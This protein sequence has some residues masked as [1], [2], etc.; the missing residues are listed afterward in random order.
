[1]IIRSLRNI[2]KGYN[3]RGGVLIDT[4]DEPPPHIT[5]ET[6]GHGKVS[7]S[8]DFPKEIMLNVSMHSSKI[9]SNVTFSRK[10]GDEQVKTISLYD[11]QKMDLGSAIQN[12]FSC[13]A[14]VKIS[15]ENG[16]YVLNNDDVHKYFVGKTFDGYQIVTESDF[17]YTKE[18]LTIQYPIYEYVDSDGIVLQNGCVA[19]RIIYPYGGF[20]EYGVH[21]KR[22]EP[23]VFFI[24]RNF[25]M[26]I[27]PLSSIRDL[28]P[29]TDTLLKSNKYFVGV[30]NFSRTQKQSLYDD[31]LKGECKFNLKYKNQTQQFISNALIWHEKTN[32]MQIHFIQK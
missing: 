16:G 14:E 10:I 1:M 24:N 2:S 31:I 5:F 6:S 19:S 4:S 3:H 11:S 22:I 29:T 32:L 20:F 27:L 9:E 12:K 25:G 21:P 18:F 17:L 28:D 23:C 30:K 8:N 7:V 15:F 26:N 13:C